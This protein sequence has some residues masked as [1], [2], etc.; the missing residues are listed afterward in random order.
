MIIASCNKSWLDVNTDPNNPESAIPE[1]ILPSATVSVASVIG[2]YY[3]LLGG[4]WSQYWTQSP[5]SNQYKNMD[6]YQIL[7]SDFQDQWSQIYAGTLKNFRLVREESLK[8][9]NNAYVFMATAMECYTYQVLVD[10]YDQIPFNDALN[11][12]A[13]QN[14]QPHYDNAITVYDSIAARLEK[15]TSLD[16]SEALITDQKK[17]DFIFNN[18]DGS[19]D[20][21]DEMANWQAFANTLLLKIYIR[22]MY[23]RPDVAQAGIAR[24]YARNAP[25]LNTDAKLNIFIDQPGKDNPLYETDRRSLNTTSNI[26]ASGT[27][28]KFLDSN[29]DPRLSE[30]YGSGVSNPQGGYSIVYT[31]ADLAKISVV[32]LNANDPVYFLSKA[33]SYLLQAEV[34]ARG[35][36]T[37]IYG[38]DK[39]L[40]Y[41]GLNAAFSKYALDTTGFSNV[42]KYPENGTFDDKQYAIIMQKWISMAESEGI[43]SFFETNRTHVPASA[44]DSVSYKIGGNNNGYDN[45]NGGQLMYAVEGA[46]GGNFPKRL[47]FP[48]IER[49]VNSNTPTEVPII[50][51]VWWDKK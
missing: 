35:W 5:G 9:K 12:E 34:V 15:L 1:L 4:F 51:K 13:T 16:L 40:Y 47:L 6:G 37:S 2:G 29:N 41:A 11:G 10:L 22:Q 44:P 33:E 23:V 46:T 45:W 21:V 50:T 19:I 25:F 39:A 24:L 28:F 17:K 30:I 27:L 48:N 43:E 7:N 42:Y 8:N 18:A 38:T 3:N 26:R 20:Y 14:L 49:T 32:I 36:G 31:A